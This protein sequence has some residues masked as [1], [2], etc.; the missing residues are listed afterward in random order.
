MKKRNAILFVII[1]LINIAIMDSVDS[2]SIGFKYSI[3]LAVFD[4]VLF[5]MFLIGEMKKS[6]VS[7]KYNGQARNEHYKCVHKD[8]TPNNR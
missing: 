1:L 2:G 5:G 7:R 8:F 6:A 4:L 3:I